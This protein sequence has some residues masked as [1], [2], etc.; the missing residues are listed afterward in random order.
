M[1]QDVIYAFLS[2]RQRQKLVQDDPLIVPADLALGHRE[3]EFSRLIGMRGIRAQVV[4][5]CIVKKEH[6]HMKLRDDR[7]LVV[8]SIPQKS[9]ECVGIPREIESDG[10]I[11][12]EIL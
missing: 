11:A 2:N 5:H 4:D 7:V 6:R 10:S 3:D 9:R 8:S 12:R 1:L